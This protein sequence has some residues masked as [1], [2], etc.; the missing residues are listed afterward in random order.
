MTPAD[1]TAFIIFTKAPIPGEVKTRLCPPLTADEA[2]S[3]HGTLVLDAIERTKGL[4]GARLYVAGAPDITHPFFKVLAGRFQATL[5]AQHGSDLGE[6]MHHA[7]QDVFALGHCSAV[8]TG[9]DLPALPRAY[10]LEAL[11]LIPVHDLVLGPTR[12]G[13]YYLIGLRRLMPELFH[14]IAWSTSSVRADTLAKA[15]DL[16]LAV[17][18]LPESRDLDDLDDLHAFIALAGKDGHISK[19]TGGTLRLIEGRLKERKL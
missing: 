2:A 17:G 16:G 11:K 7:F 8:L 13:G 4:A 5:L 1:S 9:V 10:L 3:L 18:L 6:R 15:Q 12:D 19:R 14:N